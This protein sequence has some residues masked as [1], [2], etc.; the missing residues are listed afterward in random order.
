MEQQNIANTEQFL[1]GGGEMGKL[2]RSM[3]W[4]KTALGPIEEWPQSLRTSVSL[5]LSSTFP[6]LIAWG[7]E[8]IQIY[9]DSYRPICGAKHP[10]S[11]GQNFRICWETALPVVGDAFTRG[12]HGEGTYIKDQQ[13]FLDRYGY[14]E[15]TYM[16]FSF[17]PIRDESGGV[18]GIFHPITESTEKMLNARRTRVLREF[19][20]SLAKAKSVAEI[21]RVTAE[22]YD[23]YQYDL[24]FLMF[25]QIDYASGLAQLVS[26]AGIPESLPIPDHINIEDPANNWE[27]QRVLKSGANTQINIDEWL[28]GQPIGPFAEIPTTAMVLPLRITGQPEI[29]GFMIAGVSACRELDPEYLSFY[30]LLANTHNTAVSSV[31]AYVQEQN[32][33]EALAAI[34]RS[35]TAFFSN[36]S[37]EFRTPL[38]LMLGPLEDILDKDNLSDDVKEPLDTVYRN[39]VRL[40]KLVNNLLDYSRVEAGRAQ[41][42]YQ[43]IDL[44]ESTTDLAS[45]FRSIIEKAGMELIVDC[46]EINGVVYADRQ[47]WE[48]I[49]LNLL[50]NAF[51]YTLEGSIRVSLQQEGNFV[52]LRLQDTGVG[53]PE[54][55]LPHMF[56]R[57]HRIE[58]SAGRTHEGTGIGLS[59]V[60]ELVNLHGGDI[61]V[62]SI[63]GTGST[64]TVKIPLG[65][66]HL[67]QEQ[68]LQKAKEIDSTALTGAF[69]KEAFTLLQDQL[70]HPD[71]QSANSPTTV[72]DIT[73]S[74]ETRILIVD[75]NADMRDYLQRL[76]D[77]YFTVVLA[78]NGED[79]LAK[80]ENINPDL[81]LSDIMMPVMDGTTMLK[82]VRANASS[83]HLPVIFLSARA[84]EEARI[85]GLEAGADDYLVKPFSAAEL[86]TKVRAQIKISTARGMAEQQLRDLLMQ[87]PVAIAI[88]RGKDH[89]V[90]MANERMLQYWG[91]SAE[92]TFN[93]PLLQAIPELKTQGFDRLM[94]RLL[95]SG[96]RVTISEIPVFVDRHGSRDTVFTN[97][98]LEPLKNA[99]GVIT[100]TMAV[101]ADVTEQV[102]ARKELEKTTD[103]LQLAMDAAGMGNWIAVSG[104]GILEISRQAR[105]IHGLPA[106]L[107]ISVNDATMMIVPEHRDR[108]LASIKHAVDT[109]ERFDEDYQIQ[110]YNSGRRKWLNTTGKIEL[111]NDG[112]VK[113][114]IGTILD[115]TEA[116][117]DALRKDDFI[118]MVS[119]ELK[120]P[121]TSLVGYSQ[122]LDLHARRTKDAFAKDK[123]DK[124]L[125]QVKKMNTMI[126]GFLNVSRLESGKIQLNKHL[127]SMNTL[128]HE[129]I[130]DLGV[131]TGTHQ[132]SF[133]ECPDTNI[134]ADRDKIGTV[135]SNLISNAVK[136]SPAAMQIVISCI[137]KEQSVI[138]SVTDEGMGIA[139]A[140]LERL[141]DRYF[142]AENKQM[143]HISGFGI[144]LYLC[145][146]IIT[147]HEGRIWADSEVGKG[148]VFHFELPLE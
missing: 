26:S 93:K 142:R 139:P 96:H 1:S 39:A 98:T 97:L 114:V 32:R 125:I 51:K 33:A 14:I 37:H 7:P 89:M 90:E 68:V 141:F 30:D 137:T 22:K 45:S 29:F 69:I 94:E 121:L 109:R 118:G 123:I 46:R 135:L 72:H 16:T 132:L 18:G 21:G 148:S 58:N 28:G 74:Q 42:A 80:I 10:E 95:Q 120:T 104:T 129:T 99:D 57:F 144:G 100:G 31:Y 47:M 40:L 3:D 56:E 12:Q 2:I 136:Y 55:E 143:E 113:A 20:A 43:E 102:I 117:E 128:I 127:F 5:C 115:I 131:R 53:I 35:K 105:V 112:S 111:N 38:T 145:A 134:L 110:P 130:E 60:H 23:E 75:D 73:Q 64:F 62:E 13:M 81:V 82:H 88:Y 15:E 92:D 70:S 66:A 54:K 83:A 85:F 77:P 147:R 84:G 25:Y 133:L 52:V 126:N 49:V 67:P 11:M 8:T 122:I 41:A 71:V 50:S 44:P 19:G 124:V 138:I 86:L 116:K 65:K 27:L 91:R 107:E 78:I 140:D 106:D 17:A 36:V 34:D 6:I 87:A 79:A 24:P 108:V 63:E 4:S 61:S 103:T 101:A 76:L 9:N 119:H 146:E 59:L 48:K